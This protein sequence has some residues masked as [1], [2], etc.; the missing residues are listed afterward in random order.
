M[1]LGLGKDLTQVASK[2]GSWNYLVI[3]CSDSI[4]LKIRVNV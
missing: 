3:A 2:H 1:P 4:S